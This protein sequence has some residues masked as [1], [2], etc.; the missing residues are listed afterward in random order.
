MHQ[1]SSF[2]SWGLD[3]NWK[4][5]MQLVQVFCICT[6]SHH[7]VKLT[8]VYWRGL[9]PHNAYTT[10]DASPFPPLQS[11]IIE[12][13][14]LPSILHMRI[15]MVLHLQHHISRTK[16]TKVLHQIFAI[17]SFFFNSIPFFFLH[18]FSFL[19]KKN[20]WLW[21]WCSRLVIEMQLLKFRKPILL[22]TMEGRMKNLKCPDIR[23]Y[24]KEADSDPNH[25]EELFP[26]KNTDR[27]QE[28][29]AASLK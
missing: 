3:R 4:T 22:V 28:I 15:S 29:T 18:F 24:S 8:A 1:S 5:G 17:V 13:M 23:L 7:K 10:M 12:R 19:K 11:V 9:A 21:W 14:W 27:L 20:G 26:L 16:H 25:R 6:Q 2:T